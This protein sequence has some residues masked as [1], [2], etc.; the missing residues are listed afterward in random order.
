MT[1]FS[2]P[3]KPAAKVVG[4]TGVSLNWTLEIAGDDYRVEGSANGTIFPA[5]SGTVFRNRESDCCSVFSER[6]GILKN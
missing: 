3:A 4:R 1:P 2:A 5:E 6:I